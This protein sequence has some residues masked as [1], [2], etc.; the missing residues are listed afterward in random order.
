MKLINLFVKD[1]HYDLLSNQAR[2]EHIDFNTLCSKIFS[3]YYTGKKPLLVSTLK[4]PKE[5]IEKISS[6]IPTSFFNINDFSVQ[7]YFSEFPKRSIRM[8]QR[9]IDEIKSF[10]ITRKIYCR[11][12]EASIDFKPNLIRIERLLSQGYQFGI[13]VS[14]YGEPHRY[15]NP[16]SFLVKGMNGYSRAKIRDEQSLDII[17]PL[18]KETYYLKF[19]EKI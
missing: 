3:E 14:F 19:L 9:L 17:L 18:L 4:F 5:P 7:E 6:I 1:E 16:P 2:N 10:K 8:A 12:T 13:N 11:K 15:K